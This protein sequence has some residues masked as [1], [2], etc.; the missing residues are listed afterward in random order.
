MKVKIGIDAGPLCAEGGISGYAGPLVRT[1]LGIDQTSSYHLVLRRGW[2]RRGGTEKLARLAPVTRLNVPDR[3]LFFW[4][5]RLGWTLPIKRR[6]WGSLDLFVA[7]CLVAPVLPQGRLVSIVYD[8]TPLRLPGLF[9]EHAAFRRRVELLL[10]RSTAI[11]AISQN[12]KQDLVELLD[13]DPDR[14][15]VIYPGRDEAFRPAS[16]DEVDETKTRYGISKPYFLYVGSLGPHKNVSTLLRAFESAR[17]EGGLDASLVVVGSPR[18]SR[19]VLSVRDSLRVRNDVIFT[20]S[21]PK[22][23]LPALYTGAWAFVC[24]SLYEGFGLPVLEA[25]ACGTPVI[26]S[27]RGSLPE[28]ASSAALLVEPDQSELA[29]ALCQIA[30]QVAT[31]RQMAAA[32]LKR[33]GQFSWQR[34]A[35]DA[36][37]LLRHV[38]ETDGEEPLGQGGSPRHTEERSTPSSSSRVANHGGVLGRAPA[39]QEG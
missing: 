36:L 22:N 21:V 3:V 12:T 9:P 31:R 17:L 39:F 5:D 35:E 37:R 11:I 4:W 13:A 23:A 1:L 16:K 28:V 18:W 29:S 26:A 19:E 7:T 27:N 24:P 25:M 6:L 38:A 20:G 14:V 30:D 8:L 10:A 2:L 34:S 33:A 15:H 32:S